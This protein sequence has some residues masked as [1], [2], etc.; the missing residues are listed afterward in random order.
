MKNVLLLGESGFVGSVVYSSLYDVCN[1]YTITSSKKIT[2]DNIFEITNDI[3]K[4]IELNN[5]DVVIN[6]I[7]MANLDQC[8]RNKLECKLVNTTFVTHIVDYL[9][10]KNI[11]LVHISSNAV[12]DGLNAPYSENSL[13]E[14][15]NY[16]GLCKSKAD[17][18]IERNLKNYA[19][20]RPI[21]VYG[22]RKKEQRDNPVS[23][24]IKKILSGESFELVDDNIVNMIHVEDLSVAIKKL[25]LSDLKGVYNLSGNISECRYDLGIRVAKIMGSD[26]S[27]INKVSGSNFKMVAKRPYDTSF[28]NKKMRVVLNIEP[29][30]IDV[31]I[32]EI[33]D[34][35]AY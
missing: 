27:K 7:A 16:Y 6:C 18:Y 4:N 32:S 10:D 33:L 23:F 5:I 17:N 24:I 22:P 26:V 1:V 34:A 12:Y 8:E 14:P 20:A 2:I 19:I 35:Q 28:D 21:T 15:I 3:F 9:K 31:A 11:K 13:R 25:S 30:N 29:K